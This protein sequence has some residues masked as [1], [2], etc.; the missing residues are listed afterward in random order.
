VSG[1]ARI[2]FRA[3]AL[4]LAALALMAAAATPPARPSASAAAAP[5]GEAAALVEAVRARARADDG[6]SGV[7]LLAKDGHVLFEQAYGLADREANRPNRLDTQFR[8]ASISKM[9]TT[10]AILQLA[11]AGKLDLAAPI[12]R[13]LPDYPNREIATKVTIAHLLTHTGGTGDT[14]GPEFD[15]HRASLSDLKDYVALFGKRPPDFAPGSRYAY[16]NYGFVLLGRIVERLS[17]LSYDDY[18][19]RNVFAPAGMTSTGNQPES[20]PLPRRAASYAGS[21]ADLRRAD[22]TLPVRGTSAGGGY[23]TAADLDRFVDALLSH[24]LLRADTLETLMR[25]GVTGAD[26]QFHPYDFG[27]SMPGPGRFIGHRGGAPGMNAEVLHFLANGYTIVVLA[28]RDAPAADRIA[29]FAAH[30]L[31]GS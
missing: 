21:G 16:S 25:G 31:P 28:N 4:P 24:R 27:S 6:F 19:E 9:F 12:G 20:V 1:A 18:L 7:V 17:G 10:V 13:Y 23:S 26:G 22:A 8:V 15:A 14:F 30:R 29:M 5:S 2:A 11:E 3:G